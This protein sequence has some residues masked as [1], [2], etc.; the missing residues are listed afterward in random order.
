MRELVPA[1]VGGS[2]SPPRRAARRSR[3][4]SVAGPA[5]SVVRSPKNSTSTPSPV[6]SR[7]QRRHTTWLARSARRASA[8][9]VGDERD[10]AHPE[11][12]PRLDEP[13]EELRWLDRF[14]DDRDGVAL[15]GQP[16]PGEVPVAEVRQREHEAVACRD[17][18]LDVGHPRDVR[19]ARRSTTSACP[20]VGTA[21][22]SS[23]R[24]NRRWRRPHGAAP[25]RRTPARR[26]AAG[27]APPDACASS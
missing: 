6:R 20:G 9:A 18:G 7:S 3:S 10:H 27:C 21:R 26:R 8:P 13:F 2:S 15:T 4:A 16:R 11:P 24:R 5:G 17:G 1:L 25:A 14:G 19:R 12:A 23:A 22:R